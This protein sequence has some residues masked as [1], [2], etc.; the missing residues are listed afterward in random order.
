[1]EG[2]LAARFSERSTVPP[3]LGHTSAPVEQSSAA[4]ELRNRPQLIL[5]LDN[6]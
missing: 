1:V 6:D 3:S 2:S 5:H 4:R